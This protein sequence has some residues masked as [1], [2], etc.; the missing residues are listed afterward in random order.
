MRKI[1]P[2]LKCLFG[3]FILFPA[4]AGAEAS[5]AVLTKALANAFERIIDSEHIIPPGTSPEV[6]ERTLPSEIERVLQIFGKTKGVG[7]SLVQLLKQKGFSYSQ[8]T[9]IL[10]R[11]NILTK[12]PEV[13]KRIAE[14][15]RDALR[16]GEKIKTISPQVS[17]AISENLLVELR[18]YNRALAVS[19]QI[20]R[21]PG[22]RVFTT[23]G[24]RVG[25]YSGAG[26]VLGKVVSA[27]HIILFIA[28]DVLAIG[29]GI[30]YAIN[31][32]D[33]PNRLEAGLDGAIKGALTISGGH[34]MTETRTA[35]HSWLLNTHPELSESN[36]TASK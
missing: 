11:L 12:N 9:R 15:T 14:A 32:G 28:D 8:I 34:N 10:N 22:A 19:E 1:L 17:E 36:Q 30:D 2:F 25:P 33:Y 31:P 27:L 3:L 20:A 7:N 24:I 5:E 6:M 21:A 23:E 35:V 16:A 29:Y 13:T 18:S 26:G 4:V